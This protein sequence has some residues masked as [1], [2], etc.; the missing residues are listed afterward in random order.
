[1]EEEEWNSG[2]LGRMKECLPC[3]PCEILIF[4][5]GEM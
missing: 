4:H 3:L 2:I 5:Q 1:M